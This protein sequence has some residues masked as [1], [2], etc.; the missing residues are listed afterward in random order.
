MTRRALLRLWLVTLIGLLVLGSIALGL[1]AANFPQL[2]D[3]IL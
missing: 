3:K 1:L 2:R